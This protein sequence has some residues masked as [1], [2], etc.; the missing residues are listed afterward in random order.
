MMNEQASLPAHVA[1]WAWWARVRADQGA[2]QVTDVEFGGS[3][4]VAN[5]GERIHR[6][7]SRDQAEMP[8]GARGPIIERRF[9]SRPHA[10]QFAKEHLHGDRAHPGSA[11]RAARNSG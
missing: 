7:V 1:M 2:L 9:C 3:G 8:G 4:H 11:S 10:A 6:V 5:L